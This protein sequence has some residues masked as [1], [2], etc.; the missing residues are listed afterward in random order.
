MGGQQEQKSPILRSKLYRPRLGADLVDRTQLRARLDEGRALPLTLVSAPAGY[1]KS[2]MVSQW[3]E[4]AGLSAAWLSLDRSDS[5]LQVFLRYLVAAVQTNFPDSCSDSATMAQFEEPPRVQDA[6]AA[7]NNDIEAIREPCIIVLDDYHRIGSEDVHRLL[8]QLLDHPPP[9]FELIIVSRVDP[10]LSIASLRGRNQM[11]ELRIRD[12][13]FTTNESAVFLRSNLGQPIDDHD[14]SRLHEGIEGWPVA[15][16]LAVVA[17]RDHNQVEALMGGM[18]GESWQV[19]EY[20]VEEVLALQSTGI[21]NWMMASAILDRFC[22][23]LVEA[24]CSD[25]S[26]DDIDGRS[27]IDLLDSRGLFSINLDDRRE[28]VR[29]HHLF[30]EV[31]QSRLVAQLDSAKVAALHARAAEWFES[32]GYYEEAIRHC[33]KGEDPQAAGNLIARNRYE[34]MNGEQWGPLE[35]WL[36]WLPPEIV[37]NNAQLLVLKA[38]LLQNRARYPQ[39]FEVMHH[40]LALIDRIPDDADRADVRA[41]MYFIGYVHSVVNGDTAG[42][43]ENSERA[44]KTLSRDSHYARGSAMICY[45]ASLQMNS[46]LENAYQFI[47]DTLGSDPPPP[48]RLRGRLLTSLVMLHWNAADRQA[49]E[50][51]AA[52]AIGFGREHNLPETIQLNR[53][54]LGAALFHGMQLDQAE[55]HLVNAASATSIPNAGYFAHAN[56]A[57]SALYDAKGE[58]GLARQTAQTV[59]DRMLRTGNAPLLAL[60]K[61][62]SAD[63]A[64]RQGRLSEALEWVAQ[65]QPGRMTSPWR[66]FLPE[67]VRAK[68]LAAEGSKESRVLADELLDQIEAFAANMNWQRF[69]IETHA[70]RALLR[71]ADGNEPAALEQLG[72]ALSLAQPGRWLRPFADVDIDGGLVA[73]FHKLDLHGDALQFVGEILSTF[74]TRIPPEAKQPRVE[75]ISADLRPLQNPADPLTPRENEILC[76]L[77]E[78]LTNKEIAERLH[79]SPGTV[80]THTHS[81]YD[82]LSVSGRQKVVAKARGLGILKSQ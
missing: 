54:F 73:L 13:R 76:L 60:C 50:L 27:F 39:C 34:I 8:D 4:N 29:F 55:S 49:I 19:H 51:A 22:E 36:G 24:V 26:N 1:G 16:R 75:V 48:A 43:L 69:L 14:I 65:Q 15:L 21:R 3:L 9:N 2:T 12:L 62:W 32:E 42:A 64:V 25:L 6:A 11:V 70:L 18:S 56:F 10:P 57:L 44:L 45:A 30:Q 68:V 5:D 40:M 74:Q 67:L 7:L 37:D 66:F 63:L 78:R 59:T 28:W 79:I 35:R 80:K 72:R 17:L 52:S 20:L 81:I 77:A 61:A 47:Y 33:L 71:S 82:K 31:L 41:H 38:W 53:F 46:Q 23:P 58:Q